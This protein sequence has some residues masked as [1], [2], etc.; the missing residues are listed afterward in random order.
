[1]EIENNTVYSFKML[2]G[3]EVIGKLI[4]HTDSTYTVDA[5]LSVAASP[6]GIQLM[7]S[8]FTTELNPT[9]TIN[10]LAVSYIAET[11]DDVVDVYRESTTGIKVPDKQ[12]IMG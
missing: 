6:Q 1:M 9:V 7:P 2:S 11:R 8:L 4:E 5:P 10:A 12:I 3:E